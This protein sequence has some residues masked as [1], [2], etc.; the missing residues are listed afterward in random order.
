VLRW[1]GR[2]GR[3]VKYAIKYFTFSDVVKIYSVKDSPIIFQ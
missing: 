1:A 2:G 3:E